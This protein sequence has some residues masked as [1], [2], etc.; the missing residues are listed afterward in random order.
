MTT[1]SAIPAGLFNYNANDQLSTDVYDSNGNTVSSGGV[2]DS[3]DFENPLTQYGSVSLA[4]DGDGNRVAETIAGTATGYVVDSVNPTGYPQ[5][6]EEIANG[7]VQRKYTWGHWLLSENQLNSGTWAKSFYLYDGHGSVRNLADSSGNI[8]DS[9]TYDA[10]GNL[11]ESSGTTAN[12]YLF[13]GEQF[14]SILNLYYNRARYLNTN[15]GRFWSMDTYEGDQHTPSTLHKYLYTS[16]DP[17]DRIDPSGNQDVVSELGAESIATSLNNITGIQGQAIMDQIKYGGN[18][19]LKSLFISGTIVGGAM[20]IES[21][22]SFAREIPLL[23][24][25]VPGSVVVNALSAEEAAFADEIVSFRGGEFV[26]QLRANTPGIDGFLEG[27][28]ASLKVLSTERVE[29]MRDAIS[30]ARSQLAD[31]GY[32]G[33]EVYVSAK[34]ISSSSVLNT[35]GILQDITGVA[36]SGI[37]Q[38]VN[39]LTEQGWIRIQ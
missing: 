24:S 35:S 12:N 6:L 33:A 5:V 29:N 8:T 7:A 18:A 4:Y 38:A 11:I 13:A 16:N 14:D 15:T 1:L 3:Y 21:F 20:A 23:K 9:Y 25:G 32:F 10:F 2:A 27:V 34:K 17:S 37:V 19:G 26:G 36:K 31:A 30:L 22:G 28:P 39:I